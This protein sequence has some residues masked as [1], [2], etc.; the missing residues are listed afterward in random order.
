[1]SQLMHQLNIQDAGSWSVRASNSLIKHS[2]E[3]EVVDIYEILGDF[4][5]WLRNEIVR[6]QNP[7]LKNKSTDP[8]QYPFKPE[9]FLIRLSDGLLHLIN[10]RMYHP[11]PRLHLEKLFLQV[12]SEMMLDR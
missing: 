4:Y 5:R 2:E 7:T 9:P 6:I 1:F 11:D 3:A 10:N 12:L 8:P